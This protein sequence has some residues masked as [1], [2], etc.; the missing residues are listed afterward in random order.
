ML[1][2]N[3]VFLGEIIQRVV[4][5]RGSFVILLLFKWLNKPTSLT[6]SGFKVVKECTLDT[7]F[8]ENFLM[9]PC[10]LPPVQFNVFIDFLS[11]Y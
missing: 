11:L 1:L 10:V 4:S 5:L 6:Q 8:E 9:G 2:P 3:P 7:R